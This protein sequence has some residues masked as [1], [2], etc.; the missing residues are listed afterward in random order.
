MRVRRIDLGTLQKPVKRADGSMVVQARFTRSGVFEYRKPDG[1]VQREYRSPDQVFSK[2]S[3]DSFKL[4]P[5]TNDHPPE[6]IN[7][8]NAKQYTAGFTGQDVHR[9]GIWMVG[10]IAITDAG[11][12]NDLEAGKN[13]ISNGYDCDLVM[14]P[15]VSPEG[16][17]YDC[18]QTNIGG[19]HVALVWNARAGSDAAVRMDA[20][21]CDDNGQQANKENI[22]NLEQALAA[23]AAAQKENGALTARADAADKALEASKKEADKQAARADSLDEELKKEKKAHTDAV[24]AAPAKVRARM[25]LE[26]KATVLL[27]TKAP[28]FDAMDDDSIKLAVIKEVTG[29]DCAGKSP[30]YIEARYDAAIEQADKSGEV[31]KAA[32]DVVVKNHTDGANA[33]GNAW[34]T[35]RDEAAKK[36]HKF[37]APGTK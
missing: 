11:A 16:E 19:N 14:T 1:T 35:M 7:P 6:M 36:Q 24:T 15:G 5:F 26:Q 31:F 29:T 17:H 37:I 21:I 28:K 27:G 33:G 10:S 4:V 12:V 8:T 30:A 34:D 32:N 2:E 9:D 18:M 22:M 23:L 25:A 20:A 3:M 13:Q